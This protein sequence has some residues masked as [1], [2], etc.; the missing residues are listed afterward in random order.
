MAHGGRIGFKDNPLK[1]FDTKK[2][3]II[4]GLEKKRVSTKVDLYADAL[5]EFNAGIKEVHC[6][7]EDEYQSV[8][9][10]LFH[11]GKT[12]LIEHDMETLELN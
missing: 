7:K 9:R 4:Q 1:N 12:N 11:H 6:L 8:S 5:S 10:W 2:E 3:R